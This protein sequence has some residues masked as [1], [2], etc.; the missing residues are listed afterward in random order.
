MAAM[1]R[2]TW[3][4]D[5]ESYD[6]QSTYYLVT[7]GE[8]M[9]TIEWRMPQGQHPTGSWDE[10]TASRLAA[11]LQRYAVEHR[12]H[13]RHSIRN[14]SG[15]VPLKWIGVVLLTSTGVSRSGYRTRVEV[16]AVEAELAQRARGRSVAR[17]NE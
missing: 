5:G 12:L 13:R 2:E 8:G 17:P 10:A 4:V 11:P 14:S 7:G 9:Y 3:V 6:V 16:E 15:V 1:G